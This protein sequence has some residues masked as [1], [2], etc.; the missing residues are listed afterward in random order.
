MQ[1]FHIKSIVLGIGIGIILTSMIGMIYYA[2]A[3]KPVMSKEE[4]I[5]KAKEYGL[6]ESNEIMNSQSPQPSPV[7]SVNNINK[8]DNKAT[9]TKDGNTKD[10]AQGPVQSADKPTDKPI[11]NPIDSPVDSPTVSPAAGPTEEISVEEIVTLVIA[12][13]D[14][15]EAV[16]RK[17]LDAGLISSK[18]EFINRITEMGLTSEINVGEFKIKKGTDVT[19]M[20]NMITGR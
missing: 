6:V 10:S 8:D 12:Q 11:G 4:I 2:G 16:S 14:T 19:T 17:L 1:S 13:G 5:G 15:S 9:G 18:D 7:Q 20:I 3:A